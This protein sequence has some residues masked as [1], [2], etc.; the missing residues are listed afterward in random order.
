MS[1]NYSANQY[2][3]AFKSQRLQNWSVSKHCK[4]RPAAL[5][6]HTTFI[7]NDRGHLLPEVA[8]KGSAWPDFKGTWDLPA[9]LPA[10]SINPTSRS[11]EGRS[12]LK[13]WG[14]DPQCTTTSQ[15]HGGSRNTARLQHVDKQVSGDLPQD[16]AVASSRSPSR[17]TPAV[18]AVRPAS[19]NRP[20]TGGE[21]PADQNQLSQAAVEGAVAQSTGETP[22]SSAEVT[23]RDGPLA[24]CPEAEDRPVSGPA[25]GEER[26]ATAGERPVSRVSERAATQHNSRKDGATSQTASPSS[27]QRQRHTAR[28]LN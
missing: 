22:A 18:A 14:L 15:P 3:G 26:P 27:S 5:E 8:K 9:R 23:G 4:E 12:R 11:A 25:T 24:Q 17:R 21:R 16:G 7:A 2:E 20:L 6:G 19:Q 1:S 10:H 13:A 28:P